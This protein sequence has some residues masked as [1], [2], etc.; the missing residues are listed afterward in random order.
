MTTHTPP[1]QP[2][3]TPETV[4]TAIIGGGQAG[5]ALAHYLARH[6]DDFVILDANDRVGDAW[7]QRWDSLRLFTPAK[8]DGLPGMRFPG[9]RLAFPTKDEQ[10]AYLEAYAERE[11]LPIRNGV[12]VDGVHRDGP[13]FVLEAAGHRWRSRNLVVATGSYQVPRIPAFANRLAP[14][15]T[16]LHSIAYRNPDQL[17]P[18]EVLVVGL[19]NSGAE[20]ALEV[21]RT[22]PTVLAARPGRELPIRHGRTAARFALPVIRFVGLHVLNRRSP[23][24]R[25]VLPILEREATPLIRTKRRDLER[26]GVRFAAR[27]ADVRDGLPVTEDGD[28]LNPSA[29]IWCTGYAE[30]YGWL[31]LPAVDSE[32]RLEQRRGVSST[33]PGLYFLGQELLF[34]IVSATLPGV[35]RDARYIARQVHRRREGTVGAPSFTQLRSRKLERV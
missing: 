4:D 3:G 11:Q 22:H 13:F 31:S 7:R 2:S 20:I 17:P 25:R 26:A 15:I 21:S 8:F 30:E 9:D 23:I 18:G 34:S 28:I 12:R 35:G 27:I 24:G 6:G 1:V 19:G 29:V 5:L 32:G 14:T 10:A 16:Q 33:V